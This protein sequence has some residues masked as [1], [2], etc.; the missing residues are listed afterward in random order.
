MGLPGRTS[1]LRDWRCECRKC[2]K[3]PETPSQHETEASENSD[4]SKN[5]R[6]AEAWQRADFISRW[7][8]VSFGA[9][10][11]SK[12]LSTFGPVIGESQAVTAVTAV[13]GAASAA[14]RN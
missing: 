11:C 14:L 6:A 9:W 8:P 13:T 4:K 3:S 7:H 1:T 10:W 5:E 12:T 2:G